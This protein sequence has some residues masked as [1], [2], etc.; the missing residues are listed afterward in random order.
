MAI[1]GRRDAGFWL[2]HLAD[3]DSDEQIRALWKTHRAALK[4]LDHDR[5]Q[6]RDRVQAALTSEPFDSQSYASA[7]QQQLELSTQIRSQH[8]AFMLDLARTLTPE[9]RKRLAK[10]AGRWRWRAHRE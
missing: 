6:T 1:H 10:R 2:R 3:D 4:W 8:N 5:K 7:L 9:Q